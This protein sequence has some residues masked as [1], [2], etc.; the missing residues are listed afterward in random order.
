MPVEIQ[1]TERI[2]H[3]SREAIDGFVL[4]VVDAFGM[5]LACQLFM[6][7]QAPIQV[8]D[9]MTRRVAVLHE[10]N[11]LEL[12]ENAMRSYGFRHLPVV[13]GDKL[14]GLV[15]DRDISRA[16]VSSLAKDHDLLDDNLKRYFFV[17]EIMTVN[18][19]AARP[20][21]TLVEA[22]SIMKD[23]RIGCL[24]VTEQDGTLVGIVTQSD[25]LDVA[26]NFLT[27]RAAG[28]NERGASA[29]TK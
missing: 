25:F 14:V 4:P 21:M 8:S 12:A 1:R 18:V 19:I 23:R 6:A 16:S 7:N 22:V 26:L 10:E 29:A 28:R 13:D 9:I 17:R 2:W 15:T 5:A 3:D 20:W 27:E 11:N 24:P